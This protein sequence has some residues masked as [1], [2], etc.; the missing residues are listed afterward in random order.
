[1][2]W[3]CVVHDKDERNAIAVGSR[4]DNENGVNKMKE[5]KD[6]KGILPY[7]SELFGI[8]QPLLGWKSKLISE[9]YKG[10]RATLYGNMATRLLQTSQSLVPSQ[11]QVKELTLTKLQVKELA[12]TTHEI[13]DLHP[14]NYS[15]TTESY[16]SSTIDSGVARLV[17]RELG[18]SPPRDWNRVVNAKRMAELLQQLKNILTH[19]GMLAQ[20]PEIQEYMQI[21]LETATPSVGSLQ[22][23]EFFAKETKAAGYLI[24]LAQHSPETLNDLFFRTPKTAILDQSISVDPLLSFGANNYDAILSPIGIVHLYR[25]YFFEFDSFLGPPVGHVWLSPGGTVEL[26]EVNT[27]KVFTEQTF[28]SMTETTAKSESEVVTKD[29]LSDAV[30]DENRSDIKFG[31]TNVASYTTPVFQDSATVSLSL[32]NAK[33]HSRETTHKQMR[34][35]S[36]KLSSEIKRNFKT[37]FRTSTEVTDTT[38][39][40]YVIQNTTKRLVNYELRRKMRKVGVQVQDIGVQLCWH[41]FVDNPARDLGIAKFVHLGEPPSL[42]DL[43]QPEAPPQ[44]SAKTVDMPLNLPFHGLDTD[45]TDNAYTDGSETEVGFGDVMNHINP[46][47]PVD[48]SFA[49]PGFTL[50]RVDPD[51]QGNDAILSIR[52]LSSTDGSSTGHFVVHLNYIHWHDS[53]NINIKLTLNWTPSKKSTEDANA[54]YARRIKLYNVEKARKYKEAFY[55][56]SRD[57]INLASKIASRPAEILREEE[58]IVVY[59]KLISQLMSV[60]THQSNHV[61]SELV[62]SIF[63]VDKMLYF[64]APEWWIPRLHRSSQHLGQEQPDDGRRVVSSIGKAGTSVIGGR[65]APVATPIAAENIVDWGGVKELLR[66]NYYITEDSAPAKLG[67]SL[68]WLLQLDGDNLRNT[69]LN[70]P[71]VKAVI[72]IRIGKERAAINWLQQAHV[73]GSDGLDA[74]YVA[75]PGD[76]VE[77]QSTPAHTV[78]VREALDH[79]IGEI[80]EFDQISRTTVLPNPADP[81]DI[82]NH[83]AGSLPTEAVFEHGF[84]PLRDGVRFNQSGTEQVMVSQWTEILPTDQVAALEVK[85]D[86]KTLQIITADDVEEGER[87]EEDDIV[88]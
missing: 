18:E 58:R 68:G 29:E 59:R 43:V 4:A 73:E 12:L 85:Y 15:K 33:M 70:S 20:H 50:V 39:K 62:R 54:E 28:E 67:S 22:L 32:D 81:E 88:E 16:V 80:Q 30:K 3:I 38:S 69:M 61:I 9:R 75:S 82:S 37:T 56:A 79:L 34:Q 77:I 60:G 52:E 17:R 63:D 10:F 86:P 2:P 13:G 31:F 47:Y 49:T 11:L 1:M 57:R 26:I 51:P 14:I 44:L 7:A 76:P 19:D 21:F 46:D 27:R 64:V 42:A 87:K 84:Y 8:Y 72:P 36:E 24:F 41:T 40:R 5:I 25:E 78:T 48:V 35:Q 74:A 65:N 55:K 71:W 23:Q 45:D 66:D 83:F 53:S 6:Y